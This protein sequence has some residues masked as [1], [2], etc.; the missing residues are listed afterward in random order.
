MPSKRDQ[1]CRTLSAVQDELSLLNCDRDASWG[2]SATPTARGPVDSCR[3]ASMA[4]FSDDLRRLLCGCCTF[5]WSM[6]WS[7]RSLEQD[8]PTGCSRARRRDANPAC[9]RW[10]NLAGDEDDNP[11]I[12]LRTYLASEEVEIMCVDRREQGLFA[13]GW[14]TRQGPGVETEGNMACTSPAQQVGRT[15]GADGNNCVPATAHQGCWWPI[16]E[17]DGDS[18]RVRRL[19]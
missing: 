8:T 13:G 5:L 2:R 1:C 3:I 12:K 16:D 6:G 7:S 4:V 17:G 18:R 9:Q 10:T 11:V 19:R 14:R 15:D